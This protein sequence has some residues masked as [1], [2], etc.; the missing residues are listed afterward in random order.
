MTNQIE[1]SQDNLDKLN[2]SLD[3]L[4]GSLGR[5]EKA[6]DKLSTKT[7][8]ERI[9]GS[10][11]QLNEFINTISELSGRG[12][13]AFTRL[14]TSV[15]NFATEINEIKFTSTQDF[16][17]L[18]QAIRS[19]ADI[20]LNG[21]QANSLTNTLEKIGEAFKS[22]SVVMQSA[23]SF[24]A[25]QQTSVELVLST[26]T[27]VVNAVGNIK[28]GEFKGEDVREF[29][30]IFSDLVRGLTGLK[31]LQE[32]LPGI[33]SLELISRAFQAL[34]QGLV[35]LNQYTNSVKPGDIQ[36]LAR[37][38]TQIAIVFKLVSGVV[39]QLP[40]QDSF[41]DLSK[42]IGQ[43]GTG[44]TSLSRAARQTNS[45][46]ELKIIGIFTRL[47]IAFKL[48]SAVLSLLPGGGAF[49]TFASAIESLGNGLKALTDLGKESLLDPR[50]VL[51]LVTFVRVLKPFLF[52]LRGIKASEVPD[53]GKL[54]GGIVELLSSLKGLSVGKKQYDGLKTIARS[55]A[56]AINELS[57][58]NIDTGRLNAIAK[59]G[60]LLAKLKGPTVAQGSDFGKSLIGSITDGI[61]RADF[62]K[63]IFNVLQGA[64]LRLNPVSLTAGF[65]N[66]FINAFDRIRQGWSSVVTFL[67]NSGQQFSQIGQ[68]LAGFGETLLRS[69]GAA[70]LI[71]AAPVDI[72]AQYDALGSQLQVFGNLTDEQLASAQ[73]FADQIGID[74]PLSA[75]EALKATLDLVKAGQSLEDTEFILPTAAQLA[76]L[77]DNNNLDLATSSLIAA[78]AAFREFSTGV[79]ATFDNIGRA[80]D[81]LAGGADV[82]TASIESLSQGLS[83]VGASA[84][85]FGLDFQE[86]VAILGIFDEAAIKGA[87]GGT[88]LRS[89][90]NA[91][92]SNQFRNGLTGLGTSFEALF[93]NADGTRRNFNDILNDLRQTILFTPQGLRRTETEVSDILQNMADTYGRQGLA[94]LLNQDA[95]AINDLIGQID[96]S[97]SVADKARRLLDNYKGDVEQFQGSFETLL[98]KAFLPLVQNGLRPLVQVGRLVVDF[99]NTLSPSVFETVANVILL[100]SSFATLVGGLAIGAAVVFKFGGALLSIISVVASLAFN[101]AALGAGI[102][103][104]VASFGLLVALSAVI[105]TAFVAIGSAVTT[106]RDIFTRDLGGAGTQLSVLQDRLRFLGSAVAEIFRSAGDIFGYIFGN[107][108]DSGKVKLGERVALFLGAISQN[109]SGLGQKANALATII[110]GFKVFVGLRNEATLR[111]GLFA[112]F[113]DEMPGAPDIV[114]LGMVN[115]EIKRMRDELNEQVFERS[116]MLLNIFFGRNTT[117]ESVAAGFNT[118]YTALLR[119]RRGISDIAIGGAGSL[120]GLLG[121]GNLEESQAQ[122]A[123]GLSTLG[124]LIARG[125]DNITGID[126]SESVLAFD[127]GNLRNGIDSFVA[128]I[129]SNL[130]DSL[131]ANKSSIQSALTSIFNLLLPGSFLLP[132]LLDALGLEDLATF[133]RSVFGALNQVFSASVGTI[134]DLIGGKS[135]SEA[136]IGNFGESGQ[137]ALR[138]FTA[139]GDTLSL[140]GTAVQTVVEAL[141]VNGTPGSEDIISG[142]FSGAATVL[143]FFNTN[144]LAPLVARLPDFIALIQSVVAFFSGNALPSRIARVAAALLGVVTVLQVFSNGQALPSILALFRGLAGALL[145]IVAPLLAVGGALLALREFLEALAQGGDAGEVIRNTFRGI[146]EA[147]ESFFNF[148]IDQEA[149]L[150]FFQELPT[151]ILDIISTIPDRLRELAGQLEAIPFLGDLLTNIA[152][153]LENF[154]PLALGN[155]ILTLFRGA[156]LSGLTLLVAADIPLVS[157]I[158]ELLLAGDFTGALA[159]AG[160]AILHVIQSL[161]AAGLDLWTTVTEDFITPLFGKVSDA[162]NNLDPATALSAASESMKN[163]IIN[164]LKA[165][166]NLLVDLGLDF[167]QPLLEKLDAA[168]ATGDTATIV[169]TVGNVLVTIVKDAVAG[170]IGQAIVSVSGILNALGLSSS[171]PDPRRQSTVENIAGVIAT[172][173]QEAIGLVPDLLRGL[174]A[175]FELDF[176]TNLGQNLELALEDVLGWGLISNALEQISRIAVETVGTVFD[177]ISTFINVL[178]GGGGE[179][180]K[181][182]LLIIIG[183]LVAFFTGPIAG[184]IGAFA[185]QVVLAATSIIVPL[186]TFAKFA[187]VFIVI[188]SAIQALSDFLAGGDILDS[189]VTFF[190]GI[191]EDVLGLFADENGN[192][193]GSINVETLTENARETFGQLVFILTRAAENFVT[194]LRDGILLLVDQAALSIADAR[195]RFDQFAGVLSTGTGDL[196][197]SI[198]EAA[199]SGDFTQINSILLQAI[200]EGRD[201]E[202][203]KLA[204][205]VNGAA[206]VEGF[207]S[208]LD[209]AIISEGPSFANSITALASGNALDD[210]IAA[211]PP[212]KAV[213]FF[214]RL[215]TV[216]PEAFSLLDFSTI[217]RS[218][219]DAVFSG[220][221][222]L[223]DATMFINSLPDTT[224]LPD[225]KAQFLYSLQQSLLLLQGETPTEVPV[226]VTPDTT[227]EVDPE[228]VKQKTRDALLLGFREAEA[229]A[230]GATTEGTAIQIPVEV[231]EGVSEEVQLLADNFQAIIENAADPAQ[232]IATF[233]TNLDASAIALDTATVSADAFEVSVSAIDTTSTR[234]VANF[235]VQFQSL[236]SVVS[237]SI[238]GVLIPAL[239]RFNAALT[240][241]QAAMGKLAAAGPQIVSLGGAFQAASVAAVPAIDRI[242]LRVQSL[243]KEIESAA[244][245]LGALNSA[246]GSVGGSGGGGGDIP[247]RA[248]GGPV[249]AGRL[250]EVAEQGISELLRIGQRTFLIPGQNGTVIPPSPMQAPP[251]AAFG[252]G[253]GTTI[254]NNTVDSG[255]SYGNI[256]VNIPA[257]SNVD[258]NIIEQA[259]ARAIAVSQERTFNR[260]AALRGV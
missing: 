34:G 5:I 223:E 105:V 222:S 160:Q 210:A 133:T 135:L 170:L 233:N 120:L 61:L 217:N 91:F 81:I 71:A 20:D 239:N 198:Q 37:V 30:T 156:I 168:L 116:S 100:G 147:V 15:R 6:L 84:N 70:A 38:Y 111:D 206:L 72:A 166:L 113:R 96:A 112:Q 73:A 247:G 179:Q 200:A 1:L 136:I 97:G 9:F 77:T 219:T 155:E 93:N 69:F 256:I 162:L 171:A 104:F 124:S 207:V 221:L 183:T 86:T 51:S 251:P 83:N 23:D 231:P 16:V 41:N 235:T 158:A 35:N 226:T 55:L 131:L 259:V 187:A 241:G 125:I 205:R 42:T 242:I 184:F 240:S 47:G 10:N 99:F 255:T 141:F 85:V 215:L 68:N 103:T 121:L 163:L 165:G 118:V 8:F 65:V 228:D 82:S 7:T 25:S 128:T 220:A 224:L 237:G 132:R 48:I 102:V 137:Q 186:L 108:L 152:N 149:I 40:G 245:K 27:R 50:I 119:L 246:A 142:A 53:F 36:K 18:S 115:D 139:L 209:D 214:Q 28:T 234:V 44:L 253:S 213:A 110:D 13:T 150:S 225:A 67:Q 64:F 90:L 80:A 88:A 238:N 161:I 189:I 190:G 63:S 169:G 257:G 176:L 191:A 58:V 129:S 98:N 76:S 32:A 196:F 33:G 244:L 199:K 188:K 107:N 146:V 43:L 89:L 151:R 52:S 75:N 66:G 227:V 172:I 258:P 178:G 117:P 87:E 173:V 243:A 122:L 154:D 248:D 56:E 24:T 167:A 62:F 185:A 182:R 130:R 203:F 109:I 201:I 194:G 177:V 192:I 126:L 249:F 92:G 159:T 212:D 31:A 254:N 252:R 22:I 74:Y 232:A 211:I 94:V 157:R 95:N 45:G 148:D 134:I 144:V 106:L 208:G 250:Y 19:I 174:G 46:V 54:F 101:T 218:L 175:F 78:Q 145:P 79:P 236:T 260:R 3:K 138:F 49:K 123:A 39:A 230:D 153:G 181:N 140:L 59:A 14:L 197:F 60:E 26:I 57:R 17:K 180:A 229:A 29:V 204:L 4:V 193:F 11:R 2:S 216:P 21:K 202:S 164:L 143:E 195:A 127:S 114:I 12:V